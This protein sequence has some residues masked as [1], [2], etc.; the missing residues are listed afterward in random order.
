MQKK[1]TKEKSR[2][3]TITARSRRGSLIKLWYY[4]GFGS[5]FL[6]NGYDRGGVY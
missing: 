2:P 6:L 5:G 4:C 1:V 3:G